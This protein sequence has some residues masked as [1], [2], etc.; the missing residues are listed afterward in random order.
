MKKIVAS[1][2]AFI[3]WAAVVSAGCYGLVLLGVGDGPIGAGLGL[4]V[5]ATA[6]TAAVCTFEKVMEFLP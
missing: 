5:G 3:A 6:V 4:L 1:L 2:S